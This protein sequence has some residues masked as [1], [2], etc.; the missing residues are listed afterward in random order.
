[1]DLAVVVF[2]GAKRREPASGGE[3]WGPWA[4]SRQISP[5]GGELGGPRSLRFAETALP[6]GTQ[7]TWPGSAKTQAPSGPCSPVMMLEMGPRAL[8]R[9]TRSFRGTFWDK[10]LDRKSDFRSSHLYKQSTA[11]QPRSSVVRSLP[12]S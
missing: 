11:A 1:V 10:A 5:A 3:L 4:Q 9:G 12:H 8:A 2:T 6:R 7:G